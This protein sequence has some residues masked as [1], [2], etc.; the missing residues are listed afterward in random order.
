LERKGLKLGTEI[1]IGD[2][3]TFIVKDRTSRR[4]R[5]NVDV[6]MTSYKK[7]L[8]FGRQKHT[9]VLNQVPEDSL[10]EFT[11][12]LYMPLDL[13]FGYSTNEINAVRKSIPLLDKKTYVCFLD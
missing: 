9:L 5:G 10:K 8:L 3:G 6:Y 1:K 12:S 7:A 4:N 2:L 13:N 11:N